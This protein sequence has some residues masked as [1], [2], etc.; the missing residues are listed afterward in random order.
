MSKLYWQLRIALQRKDK[1]Q[2]CI[3]TS[4]HRPNKYAPINMHIYPRNK[5]G[6]GYWANKGN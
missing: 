4:F 5:W 6:Y 3:V 2:G 1:Y